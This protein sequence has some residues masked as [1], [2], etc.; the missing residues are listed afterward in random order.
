MN[1]MRLKGYL[2]MSMRMGSIAYGEGKCMSLL[3]KS[4]CALLL[5]D[6]Q[7]SE[8]TKDMYRN[9]CAFRKVP[10]AVLPAGLISGAI[11]RACMAVALPDGGLT[12]KVMEQLQDYY[13]FHVP[14]DMDKND[15]Q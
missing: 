6:E 15:R 3:R 2:G 1:E 10:Y 14:Q 7:A 4:Q 9:A 11:G 13:A 5:L 8:N 12:G